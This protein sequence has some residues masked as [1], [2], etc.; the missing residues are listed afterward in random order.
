MNE[1]FSVTTDIELSNSVVNVDGE[2]VISDQLAALLEDS[3]DIV[4]TLGEAETRVEGLDDGTFLS[5]SAGING[6]RNVK[7]YAGRG[8]MFRILN[9]NSSISLQY[10]T[11]IDGDLSTKNGE[12][13]GLFNTLGAGNCAV[14]SEGVDGDLVVLSLSRKK[15]INI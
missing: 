1:V 5:S 2:G 7:R 4:R 12:R 11:T 10:G 8:F 15:I 6:T 9:L 3:K 14:E 13:T